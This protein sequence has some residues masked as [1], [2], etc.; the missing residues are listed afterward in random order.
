MLYTS[1]FSN[2]GLVAKPDLVKVSIAVSMPR[3][4]LGY[5]VRV[6]RCLA[7]HPRLL[8]LEDRDEYWWHY[9]Q[10][11]E[12]LGPRVIAKALHDVTLGKDAVLLCWEDLRRPDQWCHRRMFA[13]WWLENMGEMVDELEPLAVHQETLF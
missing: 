7:P 2:K 3:W 8:K 11:L 6:L 9:R 1:R 5:P 10:Q 13:N 4:G 12:D